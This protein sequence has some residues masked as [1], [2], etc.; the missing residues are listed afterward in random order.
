MS[1]NKEFYGIIAGSGFKSFGEN[2]ESIAIE[3]IYGLP[4]APF[5]KIHISNKQIF[6]LPRHGDDLLIPPHAINYR[7]NLKAFKELGVSTV[8]SL[9]T[10]GVI[11][12]GQH[13]GDIVIPDQIIDYTWGREHSIYDGQEKIV[14]ED[15]TDPFSLSLRKS[16]LVAADNVNVPVHSGGVYAVTQGPRLE[17]A[18]EVDRLE[19]DGSDYI[20]MTLM[21]EA[22]LARELGLKFACISLIVNYVAGRGKK[23][24]HDDLE[25][26]TKIATSRAML[27]LNSFFK[28]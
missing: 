2:A 28:D 9:N 3:T 13:P 12:K 20:G 25:E 6:L 15:F 23:S 11:A 5:R 10:V 1:K 7:A 4:S 24:I 27:I 22:I 19:N 18:A 16:L 21:P 26:G 14:H 17:S 8:L